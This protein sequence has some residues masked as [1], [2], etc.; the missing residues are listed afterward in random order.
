M[1]S[2]T[3]FADTSSEI[4]ALRNQSFT[5]LVALIV[6]SST[7]TFVLYRQASIVGKEVD[8]E[9]LLIKNYGLAQPLIMNFVNQLG[10]YGMAHPDIRPI[11]NKYGIVAAPTQPI[12]AAP[13]H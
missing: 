7:L 3:N 8:G 10:A 11:L 5:L 13:R 1:N 6:V 2:D 4:A 9:R 12:P